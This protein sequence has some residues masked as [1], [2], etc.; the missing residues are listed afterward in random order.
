[1][2]EIE[3]QRRLCFTKASLLLVS[4]MLT[5]TTGTVQG[6]LLTGETDSDTTSR[7][8]LGTAVRAAVARVEP[9]IVRLLPVVVWDSYSFP[10]LR[11]EGTRSLHARTTLAFGSCAVS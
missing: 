9:S 1:M 5:A 11:A 10:R 4:V 2:S 7:D 8:E 6:N 3:S